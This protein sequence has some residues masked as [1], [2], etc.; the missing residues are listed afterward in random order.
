MEKKFWEVFMK[1]N[2][3]NLIKKNLEL[4]K[5]L[6]G[7][8]AKYMSNGKNIIILLIDKKDLIK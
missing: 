3:K 7:K 6:K 1:K 2:C 4:K 8:D 5:E